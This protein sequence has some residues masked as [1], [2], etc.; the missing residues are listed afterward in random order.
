MKYNEDLAKEVFDNNAT[1]LGDTISELDYWSG[2]EIVNEK[3][4]CKAVKEYT[5]Q[6]QDNPPAP[7]LYTEAQVREAIRMSRENTLGEKWGETTVD[8]DSTPDE[9]IAHLKSS[10]P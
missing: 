4:F 7:D 3:D 8:F 6:L 1:L 10:R 2:R 9:I 5:E